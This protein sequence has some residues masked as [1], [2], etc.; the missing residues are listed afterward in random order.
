MR[1]KCLDFGKEVNGIS[2]NPWKEAEQRGLGLLNI[3]SGTGIRA[4]GPRFDEI[5]IERDLEQR[6]DWQQISHDEDQD[7]A[8]IC[9]I[10]P[11]LASGSPRG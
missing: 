8:Q 5:G 7:F 6:I 3:C 4:R 9:P 10:R 11:G 1:R 2:S